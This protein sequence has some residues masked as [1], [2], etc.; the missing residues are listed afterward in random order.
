MLRTDIVTAYLGTQE[1]DRIL[2]GD[3]IIVWEQLIPVNMLGYYTPD[4]EDL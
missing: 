4:P 2:I 3:T 1:L